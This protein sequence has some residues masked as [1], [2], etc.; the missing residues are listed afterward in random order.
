[1]NKAFHE[2]GGPPKFF[3]AQCDLPSRKSD[4]ID[5]FWFCGNDEDRIFLIIAE[6]VQVEK[7]AFCE[8]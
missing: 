1:M 5:K 8:L 4:L 6:S 7:Q 3:S 2:D